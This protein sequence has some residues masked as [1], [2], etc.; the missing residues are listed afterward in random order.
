MQKSD[1]TRFDYIIGMVCPSFASAPS[2][3]STDSSRSNRTRWCVS[4]PSTRTVWSQT[5]EP[6]GGVLQNMRNIEKAKPANSTAKS[7]HRLVIRRKSTQ[8]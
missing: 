6:V 3:N 2:T 8:H 7:T 5:D 1:F 4:S